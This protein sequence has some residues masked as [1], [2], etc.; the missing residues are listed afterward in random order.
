[1]TTESTFKSTSKD[2]VL[3]SWVEK[4]GKK[5]LR[6]SFRGNLTEEIAKS[7]IDNWMTECKT[8]LEEDEKIGLI[9]NCLEMKK[10]SPMAAKLWKNALKECNI[11]MEEIWLVT[12]SSFFKMGARTI[13]MLTK[14][15]LKTVSSESEIN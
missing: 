8:N 5:Y 1:M 6:F 7:T 9:W 12:T 2:E 4:S 10:Y 13:T 11:D 3:L 15:K 14:Y